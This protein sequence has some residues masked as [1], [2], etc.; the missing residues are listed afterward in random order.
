MQQ[1][2]HQ[3]P[4]LFY[5]VV[6]G[7]EIQQRPLIVYEWIKLNTDYHHAH[8]ESSHLSSVQ[9]MLPLISA[10]NSLAD[11]CYQTDSHSS[12]SFTQMHGKTHPIPSAKDCICSVH[13]HTATLSQVH[14]TES[15]DHK[16]HTLE[17]RHQCQSGSCR[18]HTMWKLH[19]ILSYSIR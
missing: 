5:L 7:H 12:Q 4:F 2:S 3:S 6:C 18:R 15:S 11:T 10:S 16:V 13:H 8:F 14:H 19:L 17:K 9:K 1:A